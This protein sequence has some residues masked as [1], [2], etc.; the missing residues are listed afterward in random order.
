MRHA[1]L[2][3]LLVGCGFGE[4]LA[5]PSFVAAQSRTQATVFSYLAFDNDKDD[6]W[7][8]VPDQL[9][10]L[11]QA[12]SSPTLT[13][14]AQV[15]GAKPQD[16]RRYRIVQHPAPGILS[17][18]EALAEET[19]TSKPEPLADFLKWG[20]AQ[21]P[22]PLNLVEIVGHGEGWKG[23][24]RDDSAGIQ[25]LRLPHLA[26]AL[27]G[28]IGRAQVLSLDACSMATLEA[29]AELHGAADYLVAS[30]DSTLLLGFMTSPHLARIV[31]LGEPEAIAKEL[32]LKA[33]RQGKGV[34]R[35][36]KKGPV[37]TVFTASALRLQE[38][39]RLVS[40]WDALSGVLLAR[41][42]QSKA[43]VQQAILR[44]RPLYVT[45]HF[46][47]D[48]GQRDVYHLLGRLQDVL[49]DPEVRR[50]TDRVRRELQR[51]IALARRHPANPLAQGLAVQIRPSLAEYQQLQL[52]QRTRW[53]E[54]LSLL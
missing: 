23:V 29:V 13:L 20:Q 8:Q 35:P 11:E 9:N 46:G 2:A 7:N 17:P 4:D 31:E 10:L 22:S 49:P 30:E 21:A 40:A 18:F 25:Y 33:N 14:F 45:G 34:D 50:A 44:S 54:L 16:G 12:G 27:K 43:A 38:A 24:A 51:V 41:L 52:A 19:D 37:A 5:P 39:P 53:D 6:L 42:P 32:V 1:W 3:F 47:P 48:D 28:G 15:D 26:E 36:S